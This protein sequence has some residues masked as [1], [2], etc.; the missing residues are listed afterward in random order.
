MYTGQTIKHDLVA[1]GRSGVGALVFQILQVADFL[2]DDTTLSDGYSEFSKQVFE[3]T[4]PDGKL[5]LATDLTMDSNFT[6]SELQTYGLPVQKM[7]RFNS[8]VA[9]GWK[10]SCWALHAADEAL[11]EP[12]HLLCFAVHLLS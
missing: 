7:G 8:A 6:G 2:S 3:T 10:V 11:R 1:T 12:P 5:R 9:E 4:G